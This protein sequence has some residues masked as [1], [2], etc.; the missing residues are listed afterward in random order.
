MEAPQLF[1]DIFGG[2]LSKKFILPRAANPETAQVSAILSPPNPL[3]NAT[4]GTMG[5]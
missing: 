3:A 2:S 5:I 4:P 1:K